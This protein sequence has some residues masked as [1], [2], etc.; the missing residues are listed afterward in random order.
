MNSIV[1]F[2]VISTS[3]V[4]CFDRSVW[5][6]GFKVPPIYN[7]W[8]SRALKDANIPDIPPRAPF[9]PPITSPSD[10][11]ACNDQNTWA[12]TYDDGPGPFTVDNALKPLK[13][14]NIKATFYVTGQQVAMYPEIL[15]QIYD[16]GHSIGIHT[17]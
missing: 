6:E 8:T 13:D 1:I 9:T 2:A 10:I 16:D 17:W 11:T 5:P 4:H 12:L 15:K 3:Y 7:S 14:R